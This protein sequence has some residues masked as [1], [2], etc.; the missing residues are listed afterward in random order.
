MEFLS[1][2]IYYLADHSSR[3]HFQMQFL[4]DIT[5]RAELGKFNYIICRETDIIY[6]GNNISRMHSIVWH[7]I[8]CTC[9]V[10]QMISNN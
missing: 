10:L 9:H 7:R 8:Q 1:P 6:Y 3:Q 4:A 5:L 2:E